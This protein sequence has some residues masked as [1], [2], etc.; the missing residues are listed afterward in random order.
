M[1]YGINNGSNND[2]GLDVIEE[3]TV[4]SNYAEVNDRVQ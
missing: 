2:I 3:D 4:N 1:M